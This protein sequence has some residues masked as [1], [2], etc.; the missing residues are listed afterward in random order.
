[1]KCR[2]TGGAIGSPGLITAFASRLELDPHAE[3]ELTHGHVALQG[4]DH[5]STG[6]I[7]CRSSSG[8]VDVESAD[9]V[10]E[11]VEELCFRT[12]RARAR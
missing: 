7:D 2:N 12:A 8:L 1:M 11:Y 6:T 9:G 5:A 4:V 3:L 10:I